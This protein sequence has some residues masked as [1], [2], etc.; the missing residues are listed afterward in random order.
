VRVITQRELR[1][2]NA[3]VIEAVAAGESFV[4]TRDGV[5]VAE[6][7]PIRQG[8]RTFVPRT[9]L[10]ALMAGGPS[11]DSA[12]FRADVDRMVERPG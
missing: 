8:R 5:A 3:K 9:E 6:L 2:E 11:I 12:R 7:R 1:N 4:V 10:V